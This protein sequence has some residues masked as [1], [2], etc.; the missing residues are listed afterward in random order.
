[1]AGIAGSD[2]YFQG[3][4]HANPQAEHIITITTL[5]TPQ[6]PLS[7]NGTLTQDTLFVQGS[8]APGL[9]FVVAVDG[10][11]ATRGRLSQ[12]GGLSV[13]L[14][15]LPDAGA[16]QI[17]LRLFE[18]TG[19]FASSNSFGI[20]VDASLSAVKI[21]PPGLQGTSTPTLTVNINPTPLMT[22]TLTVG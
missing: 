5:A 12:A 21:Q 16:H 9:P 4:G 18:G 3:S 17:T 10:V 19:T 6:G 14:T 22:G 11:A 13:Q 20:N 8:G 2:E 15:R 7:A 1:M